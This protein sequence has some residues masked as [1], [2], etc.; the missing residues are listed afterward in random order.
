MEAAGAAWLQEEWETLVSGL[1]CDISRCQCGVYSVRIEKM[2][3]QLT[4]L[5]FGQIAR[6]FKMAYGMASAMSESHEADGVHA[7]HRVAPGGV[8][9][10]RAS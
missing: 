1:F 10:R 5:Q 8:S 3:M 6:A 7:E 9:L 4:P 2:T